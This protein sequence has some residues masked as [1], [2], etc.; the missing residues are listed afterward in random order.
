MIKTLKGKIVALQNLGNRGFAAMN[1][2]PAIAIALVVGEVTLSIGARVT[3]ELSSSTSAG[4]AQA[5]VDNATKGIAEASKNLPLL[6]LVAG[7][8]VVLAVVLGAFSSQEAE[9]DK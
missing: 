3:S 8:A 7:L 5:A 9:A 2:L 4:T 1:L 6:G